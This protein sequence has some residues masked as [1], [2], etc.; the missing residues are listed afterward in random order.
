M[1]L[2]NFPYNIDTYTAI[3]LGHRNVS[4]DQQKSPQRDLGNQL[5]KTQLCAPS[6]YTENSQASVVQWTVRYAVS[7]DGEK[8]IS[9]NISK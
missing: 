8:K 5:C 6:F 4:E 7:G 9:R 3:P 1:Y 2:G